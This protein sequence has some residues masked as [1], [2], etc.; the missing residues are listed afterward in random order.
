MSRTDEELMAQ[1]RRGT[2][3]AAEPGTEAHLRGVRGKRSEGLLHMAEKADTVRALLAAGLDPNARDGR[4]RTPL[5]GPKTAE[6]NRLLLAAGADVRLTDDQGRTALWHQANP[7]DGAVVGYSTPD[8]AAL[9][10]LVAAGVARPT[11][12]EAAQWVAWAES[13]VSAA[14]EANDCAAFKKWLG[15]LLAS[16]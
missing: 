11:P 7:P 2:F 1:C 6:S 5:M 3:T 16:G 14:T 4:G 13:L 10:V 8:F 9:D 15:R 12:A